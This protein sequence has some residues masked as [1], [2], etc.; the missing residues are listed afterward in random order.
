MSV[1]IN[2]LAEFAAADRSR[3]AARARDL[4]RASACPASTRRRCASNGVDVEF[5]N[6]RSVVAPPGITAAERARLEAAVDAMVRSA[7]WRELLARYRWLD[8]Y[9]AGDEFA[10]FAAD[11]ERR[12]RAILRELGTG[13]PRRA[14]RARYPLFVLAG[15]V[16]F[17]CRARGS[18]IA[19]AAPRRDAGARI[20][21]LARRSARSRAGA[22]LHVLLAERPGFI[23]ACGAALLAHGARVR[24]APPAARRRVRARRC[25][26]ALRA[27][28]TTRCNCR[29]R[30]ASLGALAVSAA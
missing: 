19:R 2:G 3:H 1:G 11:E 9:L 24:R 18:R 26:R 25:R 17:G 4:E 5:E 20:A 15:L 29:C 7:E 6:W 14:A 23:I 28:R 27:V 21:R 12:V 16:V 10:A 30:P 8:R 22:A 13:E